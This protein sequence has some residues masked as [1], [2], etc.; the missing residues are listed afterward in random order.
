M[1]IIPFVQRPTISPNRS[2]ETR[3]A[4]SLTVAAGQIDYGVGPF[5]RLFSSGDANVGRID[6]AGTV[7][8]ASTTNVSAAI[9]GF[10][11]DSV[12]I[13]GLV[14][15]TAARANSDTGQ[16]NAY[17]VSVSAMGSLVNN[18]GTIY[19]FTDGG[20]AHALTHW[21][22][23]RII[24][25]GLIAGWSPNPFPD[26]NSS[27]AAGIAAYNGASLHNLAGGRI[28]AE[29]TSATA[30]S[31][32][33]G[34]LFTT[35]PEVLNDGIIRAVSL[36]PSK[37]S[38]GIF[39]AHLAV[40][41]M[42]IINNGLIEADIAIEGGS[43]TWPFTPAN[44]AITNSASG[45]IIG[46][47]VTDMGD[48]RIINRGR[49]TGDVLAG[50]GDDVF[51]TAGGQWIG[52]ALLDWGNDRFIGSDGNDRVDGGRMADHLSGN[53]GNDL[54]K[55]GLGADQLDGGAGNDGLFGEWGDDTLILSGGDVA[56]GGPGA[57]ALVLTDLSFARADG[58]DGPDRLV[59][60]VAG[61]AP[62]LGAIMASGRVSGIET[63][64]LATGRRAVV[65]AG[66]AGIDGLR[67]LAETGATLVLA[68]GWV[69][70]GQ[71]SGFTLYSA[72]G[73]TIRVTNGSSVQLVAAPP[74]DRL[75]MA[76]VA[77]GAAA[78]TL[79]GDPD[80]RPA[81]NLF[82][83]GYAIVEDT[84]IEVDEI[85]RATGQDLIGAFAIN[86][87]LRN[88]GQ[89]INEGGAVLRIGQLAGFFNSGS[90]LSGNASNDGGA[91]G[92]TTDWELPF[93]NS[94][95]IRA[96][97]RG[98]PAIGVSLPLFNN[99][100][101]QFNNS[102][103]ISAESRNTS[104][105][106]ARITGAN[107][108]ASNSGRIEAI[109]AARVWAVEFQGSRFDNS[110]TIQA[111]ASA[112]SDSQTDAVAL[113][114]NGGFFLPGTLSNSG[115]ISGAT[116]I[117]TDPSQ[118]GFRAIVTNLAGGDIQGNISFSRN[119]DVLT[120]RGLITG[121][122]EL[123]AGND[124]FDGLGGRLIGAVLG[125]DGDD[126][127]T[128]GLG[129]DRLDGGAGLDTAHYAASR[130]SATITRS[131][132]GS[133]TVA[134]SD[135]GTDTLIG[136]ERISFAGTDYSVS[137]YAE[138]G[139]VRL[140]NFAPDAG[141]WRTQDQFPRLM[142][143]INGDGRADVIGFGQAGVMAALAGA[144]GT[145]GDPVLVL[146]NFGWDQGWTSFGQFHRVAADVNG[147]GRDDLIGFG[148]F[149]VQ[150]SLSGGNGSFATP[151]LG[152]ADFNPASG[153]RSQDGFAR[154][155]GDVNGD[156]FADILGFGSAGTLVS[157]GDGTGRFGMA[158]LVL[159]DFGVNQGWSSANL[160]HRELG[161][162]NGDGRTDIIGFGAAG[163]LVSLGQ[164]DGSFAEPLLAL[165]NFG[166]AQGWRT[167]DEFARAVADI[168]GDGRDD[169]IGFG[170]AGMFIALGQSDG[171]FGPATFELAQFGRDQGWTSDN[172]F[173][174]ELADVNGD[175]RADVVGFGLNGIY[176]APAIDGLVL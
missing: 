89:L 95:T 52:V 2:G 150:V 112:G 148:T 135:G 72:G 54:L 106:G 39:A 87:T 28:L 41:K 13:T 119:A 101:S 75:A 167:Q 102:G 21:G 168:N 6:V 77:G 51:D 138:P 47:I 155:A 134:T 174:R 90:L 111:R 88:A 99:V 62:D 38:R 113:V 79:A 60:D 126:N 116:A 57:D 144:N 162:V 104:A 82:D 159:D 115:I 132:D 63:L 73:A 157:L 46:D 33:R 129:D 93:A 83:G 125:G 153:W 127:F 105:W 120:N 5:I 17:A 11:I 85:W 86:A 64:V 143:D 42:E 152:S 165:Q 71:E 92:V 146:A 98:G 24:N 32:G 12:I 76:P 151:Q 15:A 3:F 173:R 122:V 123:G 23:P 133:I 103:L 108:V 156:G 8:A 136:I 172:L 68:G 158:R 84:D 78:P 18:S 19:A 43:A 50:P 49:L 141:G 27:G 171:R 142:A 22:Q 26:A 175:G 1:S 40:E 100:Q 107:G 58:G 36:D 55:G 161:D 137:R 20:L 169:I 96:I 97:S 149:G 59:I 131:A 170:T 44:E 80:L 110:G 154:M 118:F 114:L 145:F 164:A 4:G 61:G 67:L 94:G 9:S 130:A 124:R 147:D 140:E 29:G 69:E 30:V 166:Q 35:L 34:T 163:T 109:G 139:P 74:A 65:V 45:N 70:T 128:G 31:L 81:S 121:T 7:W 53:G 176:I 48:D 66:S 10:Y 160:F 56:D 37:P 91:T 16:A 25:S 117:R 14:A